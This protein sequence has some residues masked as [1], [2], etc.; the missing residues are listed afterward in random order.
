MTSDQD[1]QRWI[2]DSRHHRSQLKIGLA[3][4]VGLA[5]LVNL[6]SSRV[7]HAMFLVAAVV[8]IAGFWI[9]AGHI[10]DWEGQLARRRPRG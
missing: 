7:G 8:G 2:T 4:L 3:V 9:L 6:S 1:L 10:A 5:A